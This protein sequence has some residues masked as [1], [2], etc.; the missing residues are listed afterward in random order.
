MESS[1]KKQIKNGLRVGGQLGLFLIAAMILGIAIEGLQAGAGHLKPWP[2]GAIAAGLI[3]L[4]A[5]ILLL[6][7]RVWILYI[8]GCLLF[9]IPK[10]LIVIA[11][12]RNFYYP[13]EPFSRMEAA[14]LGLFSLVSL[15]LIYRVMV[16][17]TP[18]VVDRMAFTF[19]VF[20]LVFGL[21]QQD[22]ALVA[23]WQVAG[24]AGLCLAWL[25]SRKK[26]G[27]HRR[28]LLH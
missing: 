24:L 6:T 28:A 18:A 5:A 25:L 19:F 4:A 11:S 9:A 3:A 14:E 13:H 22:F 10:C 27:G 16:N 21:S 8:A 15:F 17:H 2:D 26:H 12:G 1:T 23:I 7:A 20:S